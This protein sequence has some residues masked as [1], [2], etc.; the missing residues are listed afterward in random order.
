MR[1]QL[2]NLVVLFFMELWSPC[3]GQES[4]DKLYGSW[5]FDYESSFKRMDEETKVHFEVMDESKQVL[6]KNAYQGRQLVFNPD[7]TFVQVDGSGEQYGGRWEY[8]TED[9]IVRFIYE[10]GMIY[11]VSIVENTGSNLILRPQDINAS[12]PL[13]HEWY[14]TKN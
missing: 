3:F 12:K 7:K 11:P 8:N 5:S 14:Y 10:D 2:L 1:L 13:F 4:V 6:L 9:R